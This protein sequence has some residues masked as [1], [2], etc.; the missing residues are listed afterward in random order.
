MALNLCRL[1]PATSG[2][3]FP[4]REGSGVGFFTYHTVLFDLESTVRH[5][6]FTSEP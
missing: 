1:E 5:T 4:V 3:S 6:E 2:F